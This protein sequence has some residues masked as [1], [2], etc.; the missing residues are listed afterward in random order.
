MEREEGIKHKN[1]R[2]DWQGYNTDDLQKGIIGA[3][4]Q[5]GIM[6]GASTIDDCFE[7]QLGGGELQ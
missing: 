6:L 5:L 4:S 2:I 3:S 7:F 1:F